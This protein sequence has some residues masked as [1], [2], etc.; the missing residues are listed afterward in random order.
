MIFF[1][2]FSEGK[3]VYFRMPQCK[4]KILVNISR[5]VRA[6]V[7]HSVTFCTPPSELIFSYQL[8][9]CVIARTLAKTVLQFDRID[10]CPDTPVVSFVKHQLCADLIELTFVHQME[11]HQNRLCGPRNRPQIGTLQQ[12]PEL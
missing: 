11:D 4:S 10:R 12:S 3:Y 9:V 2:L 1:Q 8:K 7:G 5:N 6:K